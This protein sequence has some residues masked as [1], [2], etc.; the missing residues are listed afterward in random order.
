MI[1]AWGLF[2]V[3]IILLV[4]WLTEVIPSFSTHSNT[5]EGKRLTAIN[6][7]VWFLLSLVSAQ[8]IWG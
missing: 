7:A 2:I 8:Y 6:I 5:Q 1:I 4:V 3:S